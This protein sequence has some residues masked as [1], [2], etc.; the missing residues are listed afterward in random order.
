MPFAQLVV[1]PPG[2][3]KSTYCNG[4][5]QFM[6]AIGRK[7]SI[8]NL[9]PANDLTS[10]DAALDVRELITLESIMQDD[11]L[12]P[13]GSVLYALEELEHNME[14]LTERLKELGEDYILFDCPGQVELFTHHDSL[15]R[16]FMALQKMGYRLVVVNLIDS[17]ALTLP[18][19]YI[20]NLLLSLRTM[21]QMDLTQINVLT[22]ID[23]LH[24]FPSLPFNLDYYTDVQDLDYLIPSLEAE[25]PMFATGKFQALN[26]AVC[27]L[28]EEFGLVGYETLAVEDKKSM[29]AL[30]RVIDRAGGYVFGGAEGA[31]DSVWQI[32]MRQTEGRVD[33]R[34]VQDR[35]VD[36]KEFW[37]EKEKE[38]EEL[39]QRARQK[40]WEKNMV[41]TGGGL[42][43]DEDELAEMMRMPMDSG[44]K[45]K[46]SEPS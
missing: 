32:A 13:N 27:Q 17:Y 34:D 29:T 37:D 45:V 30:L 8:V 19:L 15:R 7:A 12:G 25:S 24:K 36:R 9:D 38:E 23:N 22:K 44:V 33:V 11:Q 4:M 2:A 21:L 35:W 41:R 42:E 43:M 28:I 5:Q 31:G 39:E 3:G 1:G 14:W 16:I 40:E 18:S 46:R 20:A 26:K 10:Y 6:G